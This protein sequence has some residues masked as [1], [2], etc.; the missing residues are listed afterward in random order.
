MFQTYA[1][2]CNQIVFKHILYERHVQQ[3]LAAITT[4]EFFTS[5]MRSFQCT[6]ENIIVYTV[7]LYFSDARD[8]L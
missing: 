5:I 8:F 3:F 7:T 4:S 2:I 1:A 6:V